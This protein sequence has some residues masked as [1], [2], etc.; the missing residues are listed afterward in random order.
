MPLDIRIQKDISDQ[1]AGIITVKLKGMIPLIR[2]LLFVQ[3]GVVKLQ[4]PACEQLMVMRRT[5]APTQG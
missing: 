3:R 4:R 2:E 1:G 5:G